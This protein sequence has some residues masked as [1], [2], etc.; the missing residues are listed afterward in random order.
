[1]FMPRQCT[2]ITRRSGLTPFTVLPPLGLGRIYDIQGEK[3]QAG[4]AFGTAADLAPA[5][6]EAQYMMARWC[7]SRNDLE[8]AVEYCSRTLLADLSHSGARDMIEEIEEK[9]NNRFITMVVCK[10]RLSYLF[11]ADCKESKV[12]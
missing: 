2:G 3:E 1:M 6:A 11:N 10:L 5:W 12:S 4:I 9:N 7:F 8:Q